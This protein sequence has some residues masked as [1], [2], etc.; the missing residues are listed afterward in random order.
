MG[1]VFTRVPEWPFSIPAMVRSPKAGG[2]SVKAPS[3]SALRPAARQGRFL[4]RSCPL[5]G[6]GAWRRYRVTIQFAKPCHTGYDAVALK[7]SRH[8]PGGEC[9]SPAAQAKSGDRAWAR[10]RDV[11]HHARHQTRVLPADAVAVST[12]ASSSEQPGSRVDLALPAGHG[13]ARLRITGME[14]AQCDHDSL[15]LASKEESTQHARPLRPRRAGDSP[16]LV[17]LEEEP[18]SM[19]DIIAFAAPRS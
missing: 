10:F 15:V 11:G 7:V 19:L 2:G 16:L 5:S 13:R 9:D 12:R 18:C 8:K 3:I 6:G 4:R 14:R 17:T 1:A